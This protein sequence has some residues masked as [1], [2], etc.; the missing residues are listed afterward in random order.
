MRRDRR[1]HA[2]ENRVA[3][4]QRDSVGA[5]RRLDCRIEDGE[6]GRTATLFP[7]DADGDDL[8]THWLSADEDD[9]VTL[10]DWR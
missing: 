2:E 1:T 3:S 5:V 4:E 10:A 7:A 8:V 6:D 9:Y